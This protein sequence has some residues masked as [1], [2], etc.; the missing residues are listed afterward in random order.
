MKNAGKYISEPIMASCLVM[1]KSA[2]KGIVA[3]AVVG[4]AGS[5]AR[6]AS[7]TITG[8]L[9]KD[10]SPLQPGTA[11]LGLLALTAD[12]V[13]L[14]NGRRGMLKPVATSLAD[15]SSR[16]GV[17]GAELG[18]G[19]LTAPLRLSWADGSTW[20]LAVPRAEA[21]RARAL[22]EQLAR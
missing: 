22:V 4:A 14:L 12:E 1:P 13:V 2:A 17:A 11:S 10:T 19:R 20:E 6:G 8:A 9:G 16:R 3:G 7:D 15:H 21:K 5:A 18:D